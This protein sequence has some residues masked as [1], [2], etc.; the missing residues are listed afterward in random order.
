MYSR[1]V[2]DHYENPRN[3]G[4]LGEADAVA[5]VGTPAEGEM[6]QVALKVAGD[7]IV[8]AKF[9]AFGC[10]TAIASGSVLTEMLIGSRLSETSAITAAEVSDALGGLPEEKQ[11]YANAAVNVLKM[12]VADLLSKKEV[13]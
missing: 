8:A 5:Q 4:T 1:E 11:R 2:M 7:V 12:A 9:R 10:P 6:L 13:R 3:V